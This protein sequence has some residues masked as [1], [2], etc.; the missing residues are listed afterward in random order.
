MK[1]DNSDLGF[2]IPPLGPVSGRSL[3]LLEN[4]VGI[5]N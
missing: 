4:I 5:G 2:G 1:V 3:K